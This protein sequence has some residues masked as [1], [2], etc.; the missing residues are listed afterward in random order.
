M[1]AYNLSPADD[2]LADLV[3][4]AEAGEHIDIVREGK[5]VA[6][7]VAAT[8]KA[9]ADKPFDWATYRESIK[10]MKVYPGNSVVDM[11]HEARY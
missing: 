8:D 10:G 9:K 3:S 7:L 2:R 1:D 5:V 11:R 6:R 4:R